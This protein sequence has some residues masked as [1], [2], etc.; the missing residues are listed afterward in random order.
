MSD[1][2]SL[3]VRSNGI[4]SEESQNGI[5]DAELKD[6]TDTEKDEEM[7]SLL[8]NENG[9]ASND[10]DTEQLLDEDEILGT[11]CDHTAALENALD[12]NSKCYKFLT[13]L[14]FEILKFY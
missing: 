5:E 10:I 12:L 4:A 1:A 3:N 13:V 8:I 2:V 11:K 14:K 7:N 9:D 6:V